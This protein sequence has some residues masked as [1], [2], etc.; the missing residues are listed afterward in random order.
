MYCPC[1]LGAVL[2]DETVP[3][4]QC[5]IICGSANNQLEEARHGAGVGGRVLL[6]AGVKRQCFK[7]QRLVVGGPSVTTPIEKSQGY[8]FAL[9][10]WHEDIQALVVRKYRSLARRCHPDVAKDGERMRLIN[11]AYQELKDPGRRQRYTRRD[12]A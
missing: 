9:V 5:R 4:L 3:Q 1:A 10:S 7:S 8:E 6:L 12:P 11:R 2:N